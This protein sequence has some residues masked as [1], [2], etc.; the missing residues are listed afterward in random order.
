MN[1]AGSESENNEKALSHSAKTSA[2]DRAEKKSSSE[3]A[4]DM[5][6]HNKT[7]TAQVQEKRQSRKSGAT[8]SG[9]KSA[10]S[11]LPVEKSKHN[12]S[13]NALHKESSHNSSAEALKQSAKRDYSQ[14]QNSDH[15]NSDAVKSASRADA[16]HAEKSSNATRNI[17]DASPAD[18]A[19][20]ALKSVFSL[21]QSIGKEVEHLAKQLEQTEKQVSQQV[22]KGTKDVAQ[23][24]QK[25]AQ[26]LGHQVGN[27]VKNTATNLNKGAD[28]LGH[29]ITD[30]ANNLVKQTE[31][32]LHQFANG[33]GHALNE[34]D[35]TAHQLQKNAVEGIG[36]VSHQVQENTSNILKSSR[37]V[38]HRVQDG[39]EHMVKQVGK[40][41]GKIG[42]Q[43]SESATELGKTV[44][45]QAK[46]ATEAGNNLVEKAVQTV[47]KGITSVVVENAP[48]AIMLGH[49]T[50]EAV[51]MVMTKA[52]NAGDIGST[53]AQSVGEGGKEMLEH[54][55]HATMQGLT[56]MQEHPVETVLTVVGVGSAIALATVVEVGSAGTAT[57]LVVAAGTGLLEFAA[58]NGVR[59]GVT[60]LVASAGMG[61]AET[62]KAASDVSNHGELDTLWNQE[63][64]S[65]EEISAARKLLIRDTSKAA[66]EDATVVVS[67]STMGAGSV[68]NLAKSSL[69]AAEAVTVG[70][71][72]ASATSCAAEGI[73]ADAACLENT[74]SA[75]HAVNNVAQTV[76]GEAAV[77]KA[78]HA[79]SKLPHVIEGAKGSGEIVQ[80]GQDAFKLADEISH[81]KN[82]K[83]DTQE[84]NSKHEEPQA[85]GKHKE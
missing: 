73:A 51:H 46:S 69:P 5:E 68:I 56:T 55:G 18:K 2:G 23:G 17:A 12:D 47:E 9:F 1:K 30:G 13:P 38:Q 27:N 8:A 40:E 48:S 83:P 22:Q 65:P 42:Q 79:G 62:A 19:S 35:K 37:Q 77:A 3:A 4:K 20:T 71:T 66:F 57:P 85:D 29:G 45:E 10:D 25:F 78:A 82:E 49:R 32:G 24:T 80:K 50:N 44:N 36:N 64:Y 76:E 31:K 54:L 43:V 52:R 53:L 16:G 26:E 58:A 75:A 7:L 74:T 84:S 70:L 6:A 67:L 63:R 72:E 33:A 15:L 60:A 14:H 11:L 41:I 28:D 81:E 34:M 21:G 61:L 39:T 59:I